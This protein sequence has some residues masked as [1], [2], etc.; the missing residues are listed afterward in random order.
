[1]QTQ[2]AHIQRSAALVIALG[3]APAWAQALH[4]GDFIMRLSS[5]PTPKLEIGLVSDTGSPAFPDR[6]NDGEL[7]A[8][9]DNVAFDPGFESQAGTFPVNTTVRLDLLG[10]LRRWNGENFDEISQSPL[11]VFQGSEHETA[12]ESDTRVIGPILGS[13]N[14]NGRI[15]EHATFYFAD[16]SRLDGI[17]LFQFII[18]SPT[19][20]FED[21]DPGYLIFYQDADLNELVEADAWTFDNRIAECRDTDIDNSGSTDFFDLLALQRDHYRPNAPTLTA[22]FDRDLLNTPNDLLAFVTRLD[23]ECGETP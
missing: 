20:S 17:W 7:G 21:S 11:F 16:A 9:F 10:A 13:A 8:A 22:D 4:V 23:L 6:I 12:P 15:H 3:S 14:S 2:K 18:A 1:M 19:G 5:D